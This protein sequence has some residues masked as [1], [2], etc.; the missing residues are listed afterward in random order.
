MS[1]TTANPLI[2]IVVPC[3]NS[4]A[5]IGDC[6]DSIKA[7]LD[8]C[9]HDAE[10]IVVDD[11]SKDDTVQLIQSHYPEVN[12]L[13]N[14]RPE[15]FSHSC[16]RGARV[17]H[18]RILMFFNSDVTLEP[19][20]IGKLSSHFL[21]PSESSLPLFAVAAKVEESDAS[22]PD[23]NRILP[24]WKDGGIGTL[25]INTDHAVDTV[26][27]CGGA[28]A[29]DHALFLRLHGYDEI[30]T[31]GYWED[32]DLCF[33][34]VR[35]G[36]RNVYE[37]LAVVRHR[38]MSSMMRLL[39]CDML[40][41]INER[42]RLFFNW[43]NLEGSGWWW[44]HFLS[45]PLVYLGDFFMGRGTSRPRG[46]LRALLHL[47]KLQDHKRQREQEAPVQR[48]ALRTLIVHHKHH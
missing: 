30:F 1:E 41:Q 29:F 20:C 26:F 7:S 42:N 9:G 4:G 34:S 11:A 8:R 6:L 3:C 25:H 10:I 23:Q 14:T 46:F 28:V 47:N 35:V 22:C 45:L 44:R 38:G 27:A 16:N 37:P 5:Y 24:V 19:D 33:Q 2:S 43:L 31:P 17:G 13:Q 48:R 15:G 18:G 36:W 32:L 12:L 39:G 40:S 21:E